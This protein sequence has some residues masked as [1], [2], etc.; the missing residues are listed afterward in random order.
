[1]PLLLPGLLWWPRP[2]GPYQR[3]QWWLAVALLFALVVGLL[4][5]AWPLSVGPWLAPGR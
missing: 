2:T 1:M 4:A 5:T 3:L